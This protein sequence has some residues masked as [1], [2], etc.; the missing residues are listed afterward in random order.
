VVYSLSCLF[1]LYNAT[2]YA[3]GNR[4]AGLLILLAVLLVGLVIYK[5][6]DQKVE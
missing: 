4:P 1:M 5:L 3:L 2:S 6:T